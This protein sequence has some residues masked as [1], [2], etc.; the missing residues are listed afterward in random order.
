MEGGVKKSTEVVK[1][2]PSRPTGQTKEDAKIYNVKPD[3]GDSPPLQPRRT[4]APRQEHDYKKNGN[5]ENRD[6]KLDDDEYH[7]EEHR[8]VEEKNS[9]ALQQLT[10][11]L[12]YKKGRQGQKPEE[13]YDLVVGGPYNKPSE[14][15]KIREQEHRTSLKP[16]EIVEPNSVWNINFVVI[17]TLTMLVLGVGAFVVMGTR[18]DNQFEP[19]PI[20]TYL[21]SNNHTTVQMAVVDTITLDVLWQVRRSLLTHMTVSFVD[22]YSCLCMHHLHIPQILK[23]N[24]S[25]VRI[26]GVY[27]ENQFYL[28][29][30]PRP[31]GFDKGDL[32]NNTRPTTRRL[33]TSFVCNGV[34]YHKSRFDTLFAEWEDERRSTHYL[35]F[36]NHQAACLQLA[37]DEFTGSSNFCS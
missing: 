18:A 8:I 15:E 5:N 9:K 21:G 24:F 25:Y 11:H 31:V 13:E 34:S 19:W 6:E 36:R 7:D 14:Y 30:N 4:F 22:R 27:N 23:A 20:R 37:F 35:A 10:E 16:K 28:L 2:G 1:R 12:I 29:L 3:I 26:C 32:V 33:E 17:A